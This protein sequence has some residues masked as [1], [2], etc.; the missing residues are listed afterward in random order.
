MVLVLLTKNERTYDRCRFK[1]H[2]VCKFQFT[3]LCAFIDDYFPSQSLHQ[4]LC[5]NQSPCLEKPTESITGLQPKVF[6]FFKF[7]T[8][9]LSSSQLGFIM[10]A[11]CIQNGVHTAV[12]LHFSSAYWLYCSCRKIIYCC[13]SCSFEGKT[14]IGLEPYQIYNKM[15][16]HSLHYACIFWQCF[17][18]F[19]HGVP[20]KGFNAKSN[21]LPCMQTMI[22][23]VLIMVCS[24][25]VVG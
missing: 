24:A 8:L 3:S 25:L 14:A 11:I 9:G 15:M 22:L 21:S 17:I 4:L 20:I 10:I 7:N 12:V 6:L 5:S 13:M 23:M 16:Q 19:A 1:S 2:K 18:I